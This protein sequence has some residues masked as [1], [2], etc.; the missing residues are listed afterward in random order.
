M[1]H[2]VLSAVRDHRGRPLPASRVCSVIAVIRNFRGTVESDFYVLFTIRVDKLFYQLS[3]RNLSHFRMFLNQNS[4]FL[5]FF[6]CRTNSL[7]FIA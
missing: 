6:C 1:V 3:G 2:C 7:E 5:I 4:I